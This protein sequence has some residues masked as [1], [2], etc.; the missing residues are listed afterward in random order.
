V[1]SWGR[2]IAIAGAS[3]LLWSGTALA[4]VGTKKVSAEKYA[5]ALCGSYS[6]ILDEYEALADEYSNITAEDPATYQS[7]ASGVVQAFIDELTAVRAKLKKSTPDIDD[8][9]RIAKTFLTDLDDFIF[10]LTEALDAFKAADPSNPA[11][12]A[13]VSQLDVALQLSATETGEPF[14][15]ITDQDLL[16]AFEAEKSCEEIVT[17]F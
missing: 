2:V 17:V 3:S 15:E 6:S 13:D 9:K 12:P 10:E 14:N 1:K 8:G 7:T 16:E 4:A 5:K 11:F